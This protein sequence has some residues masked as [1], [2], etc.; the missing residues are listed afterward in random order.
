MTKDIDT[1]M[2][3]LLV[4]QP[5]LKFVMVDHTGNMSEPITQVQR[6]SRAPV[7]VIGPDTPTRTVGS[8]DVATDIICGTRYIDGEK[9]DVIGLMSMDGICGIQFNQQF[10]G[11]SLH[12]TRYSSIVLL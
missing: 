1:G 2:P 7:D 4:A 12:Q 9:K 3:I 8:G 10:Q 6:N 5:G 11:C